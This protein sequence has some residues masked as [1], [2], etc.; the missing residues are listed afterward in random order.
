MRRGGQRGQQDHP[1]DHLRVVTANNELC[2][3]V[4]MGDLVK[5]R[6]RELEAQSSQL[7]DTTD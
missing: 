2:G 6:L 7:R 4:S 5:A 1:R 3:I